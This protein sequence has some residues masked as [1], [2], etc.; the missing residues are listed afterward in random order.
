MTHYEYAE[1]P[2]ECVRLVGC[3]PNF[4]TSESVRYLELQP[5]PVLYIEP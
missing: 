1:I 3:N 4:L 5:D 2:A